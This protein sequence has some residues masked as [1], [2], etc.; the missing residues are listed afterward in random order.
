MIFLI[1]SEIINMHLFL[2]FLISPLFAETLAYINTNPQKES[3]NID[4]QHLP[5][6]RDHQISQ[7]RK[8]VIENIKST[9]R[10]GNLKHPLRIYKYR[11]KKNEDFFKVMIQFS[12][13]Q[14][15]LLSLNEILGLKNMDD[16]K[17]N[18]EILVSNARGVF[19]NEQ[20]HQYKY[21]T[22]FIK[23]KNFYFYPG[24]RNYLINRKKLSIP[25]KEN[26]EEN[27][28]KVF[29]PPLEK[30]IITSLMGKRINPLTGKEQFHTGIDIKTELNSKIYAII[31]GEVI[32]SGFLKGYGKTVILK[33]REHKF[34]YA[35][36]SRL[37]VKKG[38]FIKKGEWIGNTGTTGISTGPHL[39][40]E[41][42]HNSKL[43]DPS[44][45]FPQYR[46][47]E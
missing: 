25:E 47:R 44:L 36:L 9:F 11:I 30:G 35:H 46:L 13:D 39:H 1:A 12:L 15:T 43:K 18:Q 17:E 5:Y 45:L 10:A 6:I 26:L 38:D 32:F 14:I 3:I 40:L 2:L 21:Y 28:N 4:F 8:E 31:E 37:L 22:I 27:Y 42:F 33:N 19:S 29:F 24:Q 23:N 34:L 7:Y 41:W 16:F 20:K